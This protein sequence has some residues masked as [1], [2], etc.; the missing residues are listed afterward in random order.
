MR[1]KP[2]ASS[3][4]MHMAG[5]DPFC[6]QLSLRALSL[7]P[8]GSPP[9]GS[10][11]HRAWSCTDPPGAG[12]RGQ[13]AELV[14]SPPPCQPPFPARLTP[15]R[16]TKEMSTQL[17]QPPAPPAPC[18]DGRPGTLLPGQQVPVPGGGGQGTSHLPVRLKTP[19][20]D[21]P[22]LPLPVL[23]S[24]SNYGVNGTG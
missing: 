18:G 9:G 21:F 17:L 19:Q 1:C 14:R 4:S 11:Q 2:W 8:P 6:F 3:S 16:G 22:G 15:S 10:L 5:F 7:E 24:S 12:Q 13:G 20:E 23:F